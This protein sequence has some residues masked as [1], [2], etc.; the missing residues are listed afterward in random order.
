MPRCREELR[1]LVAID[2]NALDEE[3]ANQASL[4]EEACELQAIAKAEA[5]AAKHNLEQ[6]RAEVMLDY[7]SGVLKSAVKMTETSIVALAD[8]HED[9]VDAKAALVEAEKESWRCDGLVGAF[10]HRRTMLS[11]ECSLY[12]SQYYHSGEFRAKSHYK[13]ADTRS[14]EAE[15]AGSRKSRRRG[16]SE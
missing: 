1:E 3:C 8:T 13:P 14:T 6:I 15:I 4:Y 2:I 9:V 5:K 12:E 10:D 7:R 11:N 16:V